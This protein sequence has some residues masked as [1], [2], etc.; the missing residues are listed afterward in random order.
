M[1]AIKKYVLYDKSGNILNIHRGM[2]PEDDVKLNNAE[3]FLVLSDALKDAKIQDF[4]SIYVDTESKTFQN[5]T[6]IDLGIPD[7][8]KK[9]DEL[10]VTVPENC[11]LEIN[12]TRH[13]SGTITLD[14]TNETLFSVKCVGSKSYRKDFR[15]WTYDIER[16]VEYPKIEDQLDEIY[17]NGID[18]WKAKIKSVK[19]K[20][21]KE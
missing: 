21:P 2:Y 4:K 19:D 14:T 1:T 20:Y 13:D 11:Y 3:G 7:K 17:H 5:K 6:T 12:G 18:S 10:K 9:G 16:K 15:V 8:V